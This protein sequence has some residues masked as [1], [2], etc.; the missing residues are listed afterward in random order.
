[1]RFFDFIPITARM[2]L[3]ANDSLYLRGDLPKAQIAEKVAADSLETLTVSNLSYQHT[4]GEPGIEDVCL[5]V[6]RGDFVVI[7]GRIGSGKTVFIETLLGLRNRSQGEIRWNKQVVE[8]PADFFI[9]PKCAYTPQ[10][11]RLFSDTVR[12]NILMGLPEQKENLNAAIRSAVFE[13]D[14]TQLENGLDTVVG[15]RGVRLSGGQMQRTAAARMFVRQPELYVFDDLSSALDVETE[16]VLWDRLFEN[17]QATCLVISHRRA[18]LQ[19]AN[20]IVVLK[21]G[22]VESEGKLDALLETS[23]EMR[24]LW[25]EKSG[26]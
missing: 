20:H 22:R 25:Q 18:A 16:R 23:E 11:P 24:L 2:N 14:I 3:V 5:S 17:E 10:V 1:M 7:T 26:G 8:S 19:R 4:D 6:Q 9:P 15:P 13:A 12:D 21:N